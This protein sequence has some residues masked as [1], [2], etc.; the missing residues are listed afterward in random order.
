MDKARQHK[1]FV[2]ED[3]AQAHGAKYK[4][5]QLDQSVTLGHGHFAKTNNFTGGEIGMVTTNDEELWSRVVLKR[6][7]E[8]L[9]SSIRS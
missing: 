1:L 5:D 2:I 9:A 3:C 7:R 6:S 4:V 8:E